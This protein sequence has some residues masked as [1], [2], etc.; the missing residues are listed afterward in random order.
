MA[1]CSPWGRV[2]LFEVGRFLIGLHI[3]KQGV[4][5]TFGAAASIVVVLI[6]VYYSAQLVLFGAGFTR[7][8]SALYGSHIGASK[9]P[10]V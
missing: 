8:W 4:E 6:W 1:R 3:G 9:H 7:V 10:A 2:A 5:S